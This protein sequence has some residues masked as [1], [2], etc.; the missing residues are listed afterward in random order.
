MSLLILFVDDN[1]DVRQAYSAYLQ[2]VGMDV[3]T[4]ENGT[5]AVEKARRLLPD[6]IV[7][8]MALPELDGG[9]AAAQLR[10]RAS[11]KNIPVIAV[12]AHHR[13]PTE[14]RALA[15]G[16]DVFLKKPLVPRELNVAI[17]SVADQRRTSAL[18]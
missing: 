18:N 17:R 1:E 6:V 5:E 9:Q 2:Y 16:C 4:A 15:A 7:M 12:S 11:T 13:P 14:F 10:A 3:V 8:D